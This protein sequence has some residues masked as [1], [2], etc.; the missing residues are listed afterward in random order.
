MSFFTPNSSAETGAAM[1]HR[2]RKGGK[3]PYALA[4]TKPIQ[5]ALDALVVIGQK[6]LLAYQKQEIDMF[7]FA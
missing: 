7:S 2:L 5:E 3:S 6:V 1:E 4:L